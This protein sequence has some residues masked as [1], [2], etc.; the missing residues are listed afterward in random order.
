[1]FVGNK[2]MKIAI[3]YSSKTGNTKALAEALKLYLGKL[4]PILCEVRQADKVDADLYFVGFWTCQGE[5]DRDTRLFLET[6]Q[7]KDLFLFGTCGFGENPNYYK[8]IQKKNRKYINANVNLIGS[9]LCQGQMPVRIREKYE[10]MLSSFFY[11]FY[12]KHMIKNYDNALGHPDDQDINHLF[13]E[14]R[15]VLLG[16][17]LAF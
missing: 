3:I 1:M 6:L 16:L 15:S 17:D 9:F 12:A 8:K 10:K 4:D 7:K 5:C 11:R 13:I 2:I 14:V